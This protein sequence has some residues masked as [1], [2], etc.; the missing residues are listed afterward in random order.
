MLYNY[1]TSRNASAFPKVLNELAPPLIEGV[2]LY[3]MTPS[4]LIST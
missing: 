3:R 4:S 1:S 2:I